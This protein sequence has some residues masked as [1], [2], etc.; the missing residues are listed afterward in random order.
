MRG[1]LSTLPPRPRPLFGSMAAFV[2]TS[3][4][5][6]MASFIK[7]QATFVSTAFVEVKTVLDGGDILIL[8]RAVVKFKI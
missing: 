3:V 4:A 6:Y 1:V 2:A 7:S 5:R 8:F